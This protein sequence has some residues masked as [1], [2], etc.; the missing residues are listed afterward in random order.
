MNKIF[1]L[2]INLIQFLFKIGGAAMPKLDFG[3]G[4]IEVIG[5]SSS[6]HIAQLQFALS[7]PLKL[8]K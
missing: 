8:G 3:D 1:N 2:C 5:V 6:F 4:I 7:E